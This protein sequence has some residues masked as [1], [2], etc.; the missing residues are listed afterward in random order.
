[1]THRN[2]IYTH[3]KYIQVLHII[4]FFYFSISIQFHFFGTT[5]THSHTHTHKRIPYR[6]WL[7][8]VYNK[9]N[10]FFGSRIDVFLSEYVL[11]DF[12]AKEKGLVK[13]KWM[14]FDSKACGYILFKRKIVGLLAL[15]SFTITN[16]VRHSFSIRQTFMIVT[17]VRNSFKRKATKN[18]NYHLKNKKTNFIEHL[19]DLWYWPIQCYAIRRHTFAKKEMYLFVNHV[20]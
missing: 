8:K 5:H 12:S 10:L 11:V 4:F 20:M 9:I 16:F 13:K 7:H 15:S 6:C 2:N 19:F 14:K 1:M 18:P 3:I 17:S